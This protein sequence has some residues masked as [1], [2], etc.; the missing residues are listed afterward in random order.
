METLVLLIEDSVTVLPSR[1]FGKNY[2]TDRRSYALML[3]L[4]NLSSRAPFEKPDP[5]LRLYLC[6]ATATWNVASKPIHY[7]AR[8]Y[9]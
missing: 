3:R 9:S 8:L 4:S 7:C 1:K 6:G 5:C 2:L